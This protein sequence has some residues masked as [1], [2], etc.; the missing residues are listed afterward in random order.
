MRTMY[1]LWGLF[2]A[3]KDWQQRRNRIEKLKVTRQMIGGSGKNI[4]LDLEIELETYV[5][6]R[7]EEERK[8]PLKLPATAAEVSAAF[9]DPYFRA[10]ARCVYN[11]IIGSKQRL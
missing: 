7:E 1:R 10:G 8:K 11:L 5:L 2:H 9:K 6:T 3:D 4:M